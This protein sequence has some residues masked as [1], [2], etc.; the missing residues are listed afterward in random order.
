[1]TRPRDYKSS[2]FYLLKRK[3]EEGLPQG[4]ELAIALEDWREALLRDS[5]DKVSAQRR[6]VADLAARQL[7]LLSHVDQYLFSQ[8]EKGRSLVQKRAKNG[9]RLMSLL[10]KRQPLVNS[11]LQ[12][13][14]ALGLSNSQRSSYINLLKDAASAKDDNGT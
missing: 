2:N 5:G 3:V 9:P 14:Q 4:S 11:A 1:M 12:Y 8:M 13:L 6:A 10:E 7:L